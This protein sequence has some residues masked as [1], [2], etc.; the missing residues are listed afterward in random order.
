VYVDDSLLNNIPPELLWYILDTAAHNDVTY[1]ANRWY[2]I[3]RYKRV[4]SNWM[5]VVSEHCHSLDCMLRESLIYRTFTRLV[6]KT[7]TDPLFFLPLFDKLL[8]LFP[9]VST[10]D[11]SGIDLNGTYCFMSIYVQSILTFQWPS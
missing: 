10:I 11:L 4:C 3:L 6:S 7:K 9:N 1:M 5:K 2:L 8:S